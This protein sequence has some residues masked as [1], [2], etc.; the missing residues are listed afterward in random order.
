MDHELGAGVRPRPG[1]FAP[2][3]GQRDP[4]GDASARQARRYGRLL[5]L[6]NRLAESTADLKSLLDIV[7]RETALLLGDGCL[8]FRL[9]PDTEHLH[10]ISWHHPDPVAQRMLEDVGRAA[11][12]SIH[13]GM[14]GT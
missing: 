10:P 2:G 6:Q 7:A 13:E 5:E 11:A 12:G 3:A 1:T 9:D 4:M 8:I 14:V